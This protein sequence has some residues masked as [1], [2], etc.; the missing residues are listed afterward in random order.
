MVVFKW[1][2]EKVTLP[3]GHKWQHLEHN[4]CMFPPEYTSHG[5][6]MLYQGQ[7]VS[8]NLE[9]EEVA[10]MYAPPPPSLCLPPPSASPSPPPSSR[11]A[12]MLKTDYISKPIFV[13]NFWAAFTRVLGKNHVIQELKHCDFTPI[14]ASPAAIRN[15]LFKIYASSSSSTA[16]TSSTSSSPSY[17]S[18][19]VCSQN[20]S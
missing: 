12:S 4:G 18:H 20:A 6:K 13:K 2:E 10:T 5:Q 8:L 11:Y 1:W 16:T 3:E 7:P 15:A 17:F 9:Q 14:G 19:H